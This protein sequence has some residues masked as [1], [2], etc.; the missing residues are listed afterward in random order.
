[1]RQLLLAA[2]LMLGAGCGQAVDPGTD[3][4][5]GGGGGGGGGSGGGGGGGRVDAGP[6]TLPCDVA[7]VLSDNCSS[8]HGDPLSGGAPNPLLTRSDLTAASALDPGKSFAQRAVIRMKA[9][10][11]QM[12]PL[13][14]AA[15]SAGQIAT[16]ETWVSA[17]APSG[18]CV[19]DA[20]T[21]A[22][23]AGPAPVVCTSGTS[24][25]MGNTGVETMNPGFACRSCHL[26][27]N[28]EG[29]NPTGASATN[30]AY[31][32]AGTVYGSFHEKNLCNA[33]TVP[34][35]TKVEILDAIGMVQF[36]LPVDPVGNF[37]SLSTSALITLPYTAR[38]RIGG[39]VREMK[40]RQTNGDCNS[41]HTEQG[42]QN[43][44][45]RVVW[46]Y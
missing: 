45:G 20:G 6:Q 2:V 4:G 37:R 3:G 19:P 21:G 32:F 5:A 22:V 46:P 42:E 44:P 34:A 39:L 15:V 29:Q 33:T 23:D 8:C 7:A 38:V 16:F 24:W 40:T 36:T 13:P 1:M 11:G 31:F 18:T 9:A 30:R 14:R 43:A 26:G 27:A 28:F 17:G 35:G 25:A 41:C 12:P 10:L